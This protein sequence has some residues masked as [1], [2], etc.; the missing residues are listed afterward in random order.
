MTQ[1]HTIQDFYSNKLA[2]FPENLQKDIGHFNVFRS[3]DFNG[4]KGK[5]VPYSRKDYYKIALVIGRMRYHYADKSMEVKKA[6]LLFSNP[7]IPY[8]WETIDE[9]QCGS[10]CVFTE[11]F[12]DQIPN[13]KEYPIFRPGNMPLFELSEDDVTSVTAIFHQMFEGINTDY[14]Y[15]YDLMRALVLQL[16]HKAMQLKPEGILPANSYSA[17]DRIT[18]LFTE[19]LE[20][21]F[22]IESPVQRM[23]L[24]MPVDYASH[25]SVHINHLNRALKTVTGKT[26]SQNIAERVLQE[27]RTLLKHTNWNI[28]EVG[29]CLGFDE[30]SHFISFFKKNMQTTPRLFRTEP[31]V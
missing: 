5:S 10:F 17:N 14:A 18:S 28:S 25:L 30:P 2:C 31:I 20:R 29:Y 19:L 3:E 7:M 27:A 1:L 24:R 9:N 15:K 21:Q 22:P 13:I 26:T 4:K 8:A 12:L 6:A 23:K 16:I 11:A